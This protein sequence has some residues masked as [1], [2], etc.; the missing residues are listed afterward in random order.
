MP[1]KTIEDGRPRIKSGH[2]SPERAGQVFDY[3]TRA[4]VNEQLRRRYELSV[5]PDWRP[6][7]LRQPTSQGIPAMVPRTA[8]NPQGLLPTTDRRDI[9][10]QNETIVQT[11]GGDRSMDLSNILSGVAQAAQTYYDIR[12]M[13]NPPIMNQQQIQLG[14]GPPI[15]YG[16]TPPFA[17]PTRN[18]ATGMVPYVGQ[19]IVNEGIGQLWDYGT[20][21][22][23]DWF[24]PDRPQGLPAPINGNG[25]G[26]MA[27]AELN[28][29]NVVYK[30]DAATQQ[31][32]P[33]KKYR[34]RRRRLATKSDIKDLASLKG[35]VGQ[36]KVMETWIATHC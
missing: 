32:T 14:G 7:S 23:E 18:V 30:W 13:R 11:T 21:L 16:G 4:R 25:G 31:Y 20:E 2:W 8:Q 1:E 29:A 17:P 3:A 6:P 35:I 28:P 36:G 27:C 34:R 24:G 22:W 19:G 26:Q 12:N 15:T 10:P 9:P 5:G 33:R